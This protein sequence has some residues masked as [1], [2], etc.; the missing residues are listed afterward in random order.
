M[1]STLI[2]KSTP[3]EV[4][5][6]LQ[7]AMN[8]FGFKDK[9]GNELKPD[10]KFGPATASAV[11]AFQQEA[12]IQADGKAGIGTIE[13]LVNFKTKSQSTPSTPVQTKATSP[14]IQSRIVP[15]APTTTDI[16]ADPQVE[17]TPTAA[18]EPAVEPTAVEP[19][20]AE[21]PAVEPT[22][23]KE[24]GPE[25][26]KAPAYNPLSSV[27]T[28]P[29]PTATTPT[30][31]ST[32]AGTPNLQ[33]GKPPAATTPTPTTAGPSYADNPGAATPTGAQQQ[34]PEAPAYNPLG[35]VQTRPIP[36]A[37]APTA[38]DG[39]PADTEQRPGFATPAVTPRAVEQPAA[40]T[41][42]R[43]TSLGAEKSAEKS[44]EETPISTDPATNTIEPEKEEPAH[45]AQPI[46]T[47]EDLLANLK[48][49]NNTFKGMAAKGTA[50]NKQAGIDLLANLQQVQAR[51]KDVLT[52]LPKYA[53]VSNLIA[54]NIQ[55][56]ISQGG[57]LHTE[58]RQIDEALEKL[59]VQP[60]VLNEAQK[61]E[62][63]TK[64]RHD[65][66]LDGVV[67][68]TYVNFYHDVKNNIH[69]FIADEDLD[70]GN[71][72]VRAGEPIT[73]DELDNY[74]RK[75]VDMDYDDEMKLLRGEL[76]KRK[77][78]VMN[79]FSM[80]M[81]PEKK[82]NDNN[83]KILGYIDD[84][85]DEFSGLLQNLGWT[86]DEVPE[87]DELKDTYLKIGEQIEQINQELESIKQ[88]GV[89]GYEQFKETSNQVEIHITDLWKTIGSYDDTVNKIERS[90]G[91]Q[92]NVVQSPE[93]QNINSSPNS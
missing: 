47:K 55:K 80:Q 41:E 84:Y 68:N 63:P 19:T 20:A 74:I 25:E 21:E 12:G 1:A 42:M 48:Q 90:L 83:K 75:G 44:A 9:N 69:G 82:S 79:Q 88:L 23:V 49:I 85:Y 17:P 3:P 36:T 32:G 30:A 78:E 40:D 38:A 11:K 54:Q 71:N 89:E 15:S 60:R 73:L 10:G 53:N 46:T 5:K 22:A 8:A 66:M 13:A 6:E 72:T 33:Y 50:Y 65:F 76:N 67:T 2:G 29:I 86:P 37:T 92:G 77:T 24:P 43:P 4:V 27:T 28:R 7:A 87:V 62:K 18:E 81:A 64:S 45:Q 61:V 52:T 58:S 51:A 16:T 59:S 31:A 34:A 70:F 93:E 56:Y 14:G 91:L 35:S 57:E 39:P 26:P